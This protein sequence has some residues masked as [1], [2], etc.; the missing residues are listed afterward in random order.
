MVKEDLDDLN[1]SEKKYNTWRAVSKDITFV[2]GTANA[3]GDFDGTGDPFDIFTV[4]GNVSMKLY[5]IPTTSLVGANAT[6]E[7]GVTDNTAALIALTTGTLITKGKIWF[8]ATPIVGVT[9]ITS[10]AEKIVLADVIGNVK[11]ANIT[12]GVLKF[13]CLWKPISADGNVAVA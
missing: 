1:Y 4:T 5:A 3:I 8:D 10:V 13:I 11:T 9:A 7:V 6:L 2:G 12:A